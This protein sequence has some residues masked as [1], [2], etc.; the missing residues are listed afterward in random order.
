MFNISN[1]AAVDE[2]SKLLELEVVKKTGGG[3][4]VKYIL[5]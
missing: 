1:R 2:I 3:R 5:L 4:G